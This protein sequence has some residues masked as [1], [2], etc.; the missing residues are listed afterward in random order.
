[1]HI[2]SSVCSFW[3]SEE[4]ES[5]PLLFDCGVLIH[6]HGYLVGELLAE[7]ARHDY[8]FALLSL[9]FLLLCIGD[10]IWVLGNRALVEPLK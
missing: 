6:V 10:V 8:I 2:C 7:K 9:G 3:C 4:G 5:I 1:V